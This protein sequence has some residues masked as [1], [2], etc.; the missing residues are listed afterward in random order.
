[1]E[2]RKLI[3]KTVKAKFLGMEKSSLTSMV[4][5]IKGIKK[6][7]QSKLDQEAMS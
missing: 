2:E 4:K 5:T 6:A 3:L 1:M 7:S